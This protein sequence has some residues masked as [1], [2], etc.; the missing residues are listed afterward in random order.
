ML[1]FLRSKAGSFIA[2]GLFLVLIASFGLWGVGDIFRSRAED[3]TV[4]R[5][6]ANTLA[7]EQLRSMVDRS[8][9]MFQQAYKG[10]NI[11]D[12]PQ[13]RAALA[14]SNVQ[15]WILE[16]L[17]L[18]EANHLG[19]AV[20]NDVLT[21]R[22]ADDP[23][24]QDETSKQFSKQKFERLLADN[25]LTEAQ[26]LAILKKQIV[27]SQLAWALGG[28]I[29][30]PKA[31]QKAMFQYNNET[32]DALIADIPY[33]KY[34]A[35]AALL[36][37]DK[38][39]SPS[40]AELEKF[41]EANKQNYST[42]EYRKISMLTL[43]PKDLAKDIKITDDELKSAYDA[44]K[45]QFNIPEK[46]SIRQAV[47]TSKGEADAAYALIADKGKSLAAA[48]ES[49]G[50]THDLD[51]G[52]LRKTD[53]PAELAEP[54]FTAK[55]GAVTAP[56]QTKL[57]WHILK[58][59]KIM[60][61]T[62]KSFADVKSEIAA[63]LS[64]EKASEQLYKKSDSLQD[65]L[66]AGESFESIAKKMP[67]K[68]A[69]FD[70]IDRSGLNQSGKPVEFPSKKSQ[71]ALLTVAFSTESGKSSGL[72]E[73]AEGGFFV[74]HVEDVIPAKVKSLAEVK[75]KLI[76]DW[77]AEDKAITGNLIAGKL[78]TE[79]KGGKK[80]SEIA[81]QYGVSTRAVNGLS[82]NSDQD[83]A[84]KALF[85]IDAGS[86]AIIPHSDGIS[87]GVV[88]KT[89]PTTKTMDGEIG[90]ATMLKKEISEDV[91]AQLQTVLRQRFDVHVNEKAIESLY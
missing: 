40:D 5:V 78:S 73:A 15:D 4:A 48:A 60:P 79:I 41:L 81:A 13:L 1:Q 63:K 8:W 21:R 51:L 69:K 3:L 66:A 55:S 10:Q 57:G 34:N 84:S 49:A 47:F 80:L 17:Y 76:K 18:E 65:A 64:L 29:Y 25:N 19:L 83:D 24:F 87:V 53:L 68:I 77:Q 33:Q 75:D 50:K 12:T 31:L 23:V 45:A 43:D 35:F 22:I 26:Y 72:T 32:R 37:K 42:L 54:A 30:P 9:Q 16:K 39:G 82:R 71:G 7:P 28:G 88:T 86:L 20:P 67:V 70:F 38:L 61:G 74:I 46:R 89:H 91:S 90:I 58:I 11:A 6:G 44:D 27:N 52:D 59:E 36:G 56:V 14:Q 85:A 62:V 2:K